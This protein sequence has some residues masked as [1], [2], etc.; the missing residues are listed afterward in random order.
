MPICENHLFI[1]PSLDSTYTL[2]K[3]KGLVNFDQLFDQDFFFPFADLRTKFALPQAHLFRYFQTRDFVRCNLPNFPQKPPHTL[4][5]AILS[6]SA[7]RGFIAIVVKL[8]LSSLSSPLATR[9]SWE[10]ELGGTLSDEWWQSAL[11]RVNSTSSCASLT[12]IQFK[13]LHRIHFSKAKLKKL[14]NTSD[15]CDRCSL[16]PASHTHMFFSCPRLSSYWSSFYS[17]LSKALNKPVLSS[18]LTSI[19]GVPEDFTLFNRENNCIAF[20]P[21]VARRRILLHWKDKNPPSPNSWLKD[22]ISFLYLEKIKYGIRGCSDKFYKTWNPILS[23]ID[24]IPSLD[25]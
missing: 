20:A 4:L 21:L 14:F 2:W 7:V 9:N 3:E 15:T 12:L 24:S 19:F 10:K 13:V 23:L 18:P 22:L 16:S 5:D 6:L 8:I 17:T 11:N 25:D 1:P